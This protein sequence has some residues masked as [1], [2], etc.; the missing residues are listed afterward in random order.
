MPTLQSELFDQDPNIMKL[1]EQVVYK[2]INLPNSDVFREQLQEA[3]E[4]LGGERANLLATKAQ[5]IIEKLVS[6]LESYKEQLQENL[7]NTDFSKEE[8]IENLNA[9][10]SDYKEC[11]QDEDQNLLDNLFKAMRNRNETVNQFTI[12]ESKATIRDIT[13]ELQKLQK[14]LASL[15]NKHTFKEGEVQKANDD[16]RSQGEQLSQLQA[17]KGHSSPKINS[18]EK[19]RQF[20]EKYAKGLQAD[21]ELLKEKLAA[22]H[23]N[24]QQALTDIETNKQSAEQHLETILARKTIGSQAAIDKLQKLLSKERVKNTDELDSLHQRIN[25]LEVEL[26]SQVQPKVQ[27][28]PTGGYTPLEASQDK[29]KIK[30]LEQTTAKLIEENNQFIE[31]IGQ[32]EKSLEEAAR[33]VVALHDEKK[34]LEQDHK[35]RKPQFVSLKDDMLE[36]TIEAVAPQTPVTVPEHRAY[37][38]LL[39]NTVSGALLGYAASSRAP[40]VVKFSAVVAGGLGLAASLYSSKNKK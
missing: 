27:Q 37:L 33:L 22:L 6:K 34:N 25:K 1:A 18:L 15:K 19:R 26:N 21:N 23:K 32:C 2:L 40:N 20:A 14:D 4:S 8:S 3:S 5:S 16:L 13:R 29:L 35:T 12:V 11:F 28:K 39:L 7:P 30:K 17:E 10:L 9:S 36:P 38:R 24:Y 31:V